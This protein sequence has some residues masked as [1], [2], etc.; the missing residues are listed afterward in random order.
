M[1]QQTICIYMLLYIY[2]YDVITIKQKITKHDEIHLTKWNV[3]VVKIKKKRI[4]LQ[5][6]QISTFWTQGP[7]HDDVIMWVVLKSFLLTPVQCGASALK[8]APA[9]LLR[10]HSPACEPMHCN[11]CPC[12]SMRVHVLTVLQCASV[13]RPTHYSIFGSVLASRFW[14]PFQL[15][16]MRVHALECVTISRHAR[17]H[18][19]SMRYNSC[20]CASMRA[21]ASFSGTLFICHWLHC[22]IFSR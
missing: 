5:H 7:R 20:P 11:S 9:S 17:P 15:C 3:H 4:Y 19:A 1:L 12:A 22:C 8:P 2:V 14:N 16:F 10:V 13:C 6:R 21:N 18:G